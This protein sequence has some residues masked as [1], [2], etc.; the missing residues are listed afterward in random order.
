MS[1]DNPS[2][3]GSPGEDGRIFGLKEPHILDSNNVD[4]RLFSS[5]SS[6]NIDVEV[7][8]GQESEHVATLPHSGTSTSI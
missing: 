8:V 5:D 2:F 3:P 6:D 4:V 1:Q 7:L